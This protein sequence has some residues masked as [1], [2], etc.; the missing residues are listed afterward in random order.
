MT[1]RPSRSGTPRRLRFSEAR[2]GLFDYSEQPEAAAMLR[3]FAAASRP[4]GVLY[5]GNF[6]PHCTTR[7]YME[8]IGNG[9]LIYRTADDLHRLAAAA[10]LPAPPGLSSPP[11]EPAR[12]YSCDMK[13]LPGS[14]RTFRDSRR[15]SLP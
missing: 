6:V 11:N 8:W 4:G 15:L 1:V 3:L 5:V 14:R 2:A 13:P 10:D 9:I 7:A 12:T